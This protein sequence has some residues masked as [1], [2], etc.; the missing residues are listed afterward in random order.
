MTGLDGKVAIVTGGG[1]GLGEAIARAL[2]AKG[3]KVVVSDINLKGAERV[4]EDIGGTGGAASA[5][6]QDTARPE[7]S[8]RVVAHA[9]STYGALHYAVN[10]AG[11]GGA[12]APAGEVDLD[13]WQRVIDINLNGVLY[14]MRYQIPAMLKAGPRGSAIVNMA[15]IHGT[16][17]AIGNG[18]YTAAKHGVVGLTKNAAAEYG[19]QGLRINCVGPAYIETPLL[20]NLPAE[21]KDAL[22]ARHPL[23]RLGQPEEVAPLVC[24]LLSDDASFITGG[25][26]LVDGGY[27][28]V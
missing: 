15:S 24:F 19:P 22:V 13:D 9:V 16:V 23:G 1:S 20:A 14:G 2:A 27:T 3:V 25:Y 6:A 12:A 7:D 21:Q 10:N 17:A 28:A 4:V 26:Y 8:E 5:I 18:A 11:I